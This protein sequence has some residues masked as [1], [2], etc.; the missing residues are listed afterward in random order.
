MNE[1]AYVDWTL[2]Q[3]VQKMGGGKK[4]L[5]CNLNPKGKWMFYGRHCNYK[6][7]DWKSIICAVYWN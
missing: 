3:S 7:S 2:I 4:K 1:F 5:D 6:S